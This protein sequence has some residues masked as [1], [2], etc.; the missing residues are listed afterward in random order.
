MNPLLNCDI[1]E[2]DSVQ[3]L[4]PELE[5]LP[6]IDMANIACG[7]HAGS[8]NVM[9]AMMVA[10]AKVGV[11]IGAHPSYPDR[12]QFGRVSRA[13][14][15]GALR[16]WLSEQLGLF[17]RIADELGVTV[18]HVKPHGALYHDAHV[19]EPIADIVVKV[20]R[21]ILGDVAMVGQA[22]SA[23][24][25]S[26]NRA[27][28]PYLT[29]A[30]ADRHYTTSLALQSRTVPGSVLS[31]TEARMQVQQ[32]L[33]HGTIETPAGPQPIH[34]QTLCVHSDSPEAKEILTTLHPLIHK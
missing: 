24:E 34:F 6:Y 20:T 19:S 9:R 26:A 7:G 4:G 31:A 32:L 18:H 14:D 2:K 22:R 16:G 12:E 15:V 8:A 10:C 30:F 27:G 23:L 13:A 29:E 3:D 17:R 28:L 1:G 5:L 25:K 33:T 21:T 11:R